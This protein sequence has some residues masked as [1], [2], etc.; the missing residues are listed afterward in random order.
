[1]PT[2]TRCIL[3]ISL[4]LASC[5]TPAAT[6]P[7]SDDA[8]QDGVDLADAL[9]PTDAIGDIAV[10]ATPADVQ[11]LCLQ[12]T[13]NPV[14]FSGTK[15]GAGALINVTLANC[16]L[17]GVCMTDLELQLQAAN[18][19]EYNL[20]L[21][22]LQPLCPSL[23][24]K[25]GPST[26]APCCLAPGATAAFGLYFTPTSPGQHKTAQVWVKWN[27]AQIVLPIDGTATAS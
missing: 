2:N 10:D 7:A 5:G 14:L 19:G 26:S 15:L 13:P 23:D 9:T 17:S 6:P 3:A 12:A 27:G 16:G 20:D 11:A 22:G 1:M 8:M 24:L 18:V 25:K 4:L 21:T